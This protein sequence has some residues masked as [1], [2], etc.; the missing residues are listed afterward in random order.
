LR[1]WPERILEYSPKGFTNAR[2]RLF[3]SLDFIKPVDSLA[4]D[5]KVDA[6]AV[7][8]GYLR[9]DSLLA[10]L[11]SEAPVHDFLHFVVTGVAIDLLA[12]VS[13]DR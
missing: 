6:C 1:P 13:H 4:P 2:A 5:H 9:N 8:P 7:I 10:K 12:A 11:T 3:G